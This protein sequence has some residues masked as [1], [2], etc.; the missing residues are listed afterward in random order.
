LATDILG[1]PICAIFKDQD[2]LS[3]EI[4]PIGYPETS[5]FKYQSTLYNI[6]EE[7]SPNL[8]RGENPK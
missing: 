3:F 1:Q 2:Y 8:N 6:A 7:R 5:V 4:G